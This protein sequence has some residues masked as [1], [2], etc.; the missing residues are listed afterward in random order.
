MVES[1]DKLKLNFW[2]IEVYDLE[3]STTMNFNLLEEQSTRAVD[4]VRGANE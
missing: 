4:R 2:S 1:T 3:Q